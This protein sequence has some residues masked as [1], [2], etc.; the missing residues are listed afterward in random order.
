MYQHFVFIL[1]DLF[2]RREFVC[3][4]DS[5]TEGFHPVYRDYVFLVIDISYCQAQFQLASSS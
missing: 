3:L 4:I 5:S 2:H 1:K